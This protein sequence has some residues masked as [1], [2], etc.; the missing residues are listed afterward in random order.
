MAEKAAVNSDKLPCAASF[1]S[2]AACTSAALAPMFLESSAAPSEALNWEPDLVV[3]T[4]PCDILTSSANA[5]IGSVAVNLFVSASL[6][7]AV[8][9]LYSPA[10]LIFLPPILN[11]SPSLNVRVPSS[12]SNSEPVIF[13]LFKLLSVVSTPLPKL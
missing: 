1:L 6:N 4:N 2:N 12:A 3:P 5:L 10:L 13:C 11:C 9:V 7:L 8:P